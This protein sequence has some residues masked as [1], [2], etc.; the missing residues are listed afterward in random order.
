MNT[1]S[2]GFDPKA[3][4][5]NPNQHSAR[6]G[7]PPTGDFV[8]TGDSVSELSHALADLEA[9]SLRLA[10]LTR[11]WQVRLSQAS[12]QAPTAPSAP[13]TTGTEFASAPKAV[14]KSAPERTPQA[15]PHAA[16][17]GAPQHNPQPPPTQADWRNQPAPLPQSGA[18]AQPMFGFPSAHQWRRDSKS[19]QSSL[20]PQSSPTGSAPPPKLP[21]APREPREP[22]EPWWRNEK[23]IIKII[24]IFGGLITAAGIA[25][26]VAVAIQSGLIGPAG[27]VVLAYLLA[28]VLAVAA[29]RAHRRQAPPAG[30]TALI[31]TSLAAAHLTTMSMSYLLDWI[32]VAATLVI[33]LPFAAVG[34][35]GA[36]WTKSSAT[37]TWAITINTGLMLWATIGLNFH[38]RPLS[39]S[40]A[41][42][43]L[44]LMVI[45][46][47]VCF[48]NIPFRKY[49]VA[50]LL[51][52]N[53]LIGVITT[54]NALVMP[55]IAALTIALFVFAQFGPLALARQ[56]TPE[57]DDE[58]SETS[59]WEDDLVTITSVVAF[60]TPVVAAVPTVN[61]TQST[62]SLWLLFYGGFVLFIAIAAVFLWNRAIFRYLAPMALATAILPWLALAVAGPE[63]DA[64]AGTG[65]H[66]WG[67][68][69]ISIGAA[70]FVWALATAPKYSAI[71]ARLQAP[72]PTRDAVAP[73]TKIAA[74]TWLLGATVVHLYILPAAL[75]AGAAADYSAT[76]AEMLSL[77]FL[78]CADVGLAV[79]AARS[80]LP[81]A[82]ALIG[83]AALG[84]PFIVL[85]T[86]IGVSFNAAHM[87]LSIFWATIA[88]MLVLSKRFHHIPARLAAGLTI[89]ALS[90]VKLIFYDMATLDGVIRAL[91]FL[92][93]GLI[94]LAMAVSG[95]K[96]KN[97]EEPAAADRDGT[98][99]DS[100]AV[101]AAA[102]ANA[103]AA[104]TDPAADRLEG[105]TRTDGPGISDGNEPTT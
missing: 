2:N 74:L 91:A 44:Q 61:A 89:A 87:L 67:L 36:R 7:K 32:P 97:A 34:L 49:V 104:D 98:A 86:T 58:P 22:R 39:S 45:A 88:G 103:D 30:V 47:I 94:L 57:L 16:P 38:A 21:E 102:A 5:T 11:T 20:S 62:S 15:P 93:C 31:A 63:G 4:N 90:I 80:Q 65:T 13:Q 83:L 28:T 54:N 64:G 23:A 46:A 76:W 71:G 37:A 43:T 59:T 50:F 40:L 84:M 12:G 52:A 48:L 10:R 100:D 41:Q 96:Q 42:I 53:V 73:Y 78:L 68:I 18:T 29:V 14:P 3:E 1:G 25:F 81:P 27:R 26:F 19:P 55:A 69:P 72:E 95:A 6:Y 99:S 9:S 8:L 51:G 33:M 70:L 79:T 17:Q 66:T 60:S 56:L 77:L 92:G 105:I 85:L 35:Y 82:F 101:G 75:N 24:A